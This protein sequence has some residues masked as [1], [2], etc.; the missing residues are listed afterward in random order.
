VSYTIALHPLGFSVREA[1]GPD[2]GLLVFHG[3]P[4]AE[5]YAAALEVGDEALAAA[6]AQRYG[7]VYVGRRLSDL[8]SCHDVATV[9]ALNAAR[10]ADRARTWVIA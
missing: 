7:R 2:E 5:D 8:R 9:D 10:L 4:F 3:R 1:E 6:M